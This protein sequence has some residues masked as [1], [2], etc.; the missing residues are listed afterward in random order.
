M[1]VAVDRVT[2]KPAAKYASAAVKVNG[3][4]V[5]SGTPAVEVALKEGENPVIIEVSVPKVP[6]VRKY[7]LTVVRGDAAREV[8]DAGGGRG[9]PAR[10]GR[11]RCAGSRSR[12]APGRWS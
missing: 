10:P 7:T 12:R 11:N 1:P 4:A 3:R 5:D 2:V 8:E 6:A 9:R